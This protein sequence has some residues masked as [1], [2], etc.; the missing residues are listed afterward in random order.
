MATLIYLTIG[1][2]VSIFNNFIYS[3]IQ[4]NEQAKQEEPAMVF[5]MFIW[6]VLW[7]IGL[8]S[9]VVMLRRL[10]KQRY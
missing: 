9:S 6:Y 4:T 3:K 1:F 8:I 2:V 5:A 7:P 10:V